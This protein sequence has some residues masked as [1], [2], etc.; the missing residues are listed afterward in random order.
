[1]APASSTESQDEEDNED[2]HQHGKGYCNPRATLYWH[3]SLTV[4]PAISLC[5]SERPPVAPVNPK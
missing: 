2:E 3:V 5:E 1:M 4:I